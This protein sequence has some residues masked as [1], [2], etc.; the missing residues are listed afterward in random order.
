MI[1][2]EQRSIYLAPVRPCY[3]S[4]CPAGIAASTEV[5]KWNPPVIL[6][7][8]A[9]GSGEKQNQGSN[10]L[11]SDSPSSSQN[12]HYLNYCDKTEPSPLPCAC[13]TWQALFP[14][15]D[16]ASAALPL[17]P[18]AHSF[19]SCWHALIYPLPLLRN[20]SKFHHCTALTLPFPG[21]TRML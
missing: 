16:P 9:S 3:N 11:A 18:G 13:V 7:S 19:I 8:L 14:G 5:I 10:R 15:S 17:Q 21:V 2:E 20:S 4:L 12:R 1:K 6:L